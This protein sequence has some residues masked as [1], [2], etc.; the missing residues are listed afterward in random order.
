MRK[1]KANVLKKLRW[2]LLLAL[3]FS[4]N[5]Y[6]E[7]E[8][9][10]KIIDD[11]EA[12]YVSNVLTIEQCGN[13]EYKAVLSNVVLPEGTQSVKM[14]IWSGVNGQ[15]DIKWYT[16]QKQND[17]TYAVTFSLLN[18]KGLEIGRASCRERV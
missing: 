5:V 1:Y 18:H 13:T 14:P 12:E 10:E 9:Q 8:N 3:L 15:D 2:I 17:G 6:A 11:V 4:M 16:A 7:G